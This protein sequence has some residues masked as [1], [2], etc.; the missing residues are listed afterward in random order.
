[1][2]LVV[3]EGQPE[4]TVA[5]AVLAVELVVLEG[6]PEAMVATAALAARS[7]SP[8]QTHCCIPQT[9]GLSRRGASRTQKHGLR[10]RNWC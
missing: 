6:Q 3:L 5:T 9:D 4:A 7:S 10:G 2:E 8:L 1:M